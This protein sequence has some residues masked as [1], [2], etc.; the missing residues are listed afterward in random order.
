[1]CWLVLYTRKHILNSFKSDGGTGKTFLFYRRNVI[2]TIG[3]YD[4]R[5]E[6]KNKEERKY[7]VKEVKEIKKEVEERNKDMVS[8]MESLKSELC[9]IKK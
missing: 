1:M 8:I 3:K 4:N 7:K 5:T 6:K 2:G 9:K